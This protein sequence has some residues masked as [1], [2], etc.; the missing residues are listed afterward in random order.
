MASLA[1]YNMH[2]TSRGN[3]RY[4]GLVDAKIHMAFNA[5]RFAQTETRTPT[6]SMGSS[7]STLELFAPY[8]DYFLF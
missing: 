1:V 5:I 4:T 2:L 8:K 7:N 3:S 6:S